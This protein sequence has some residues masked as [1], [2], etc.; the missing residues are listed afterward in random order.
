MELLVTLFLIGI[1]A[2]VVLPRL[3]GSHQK[4]PLTAAAKDLA[5]LMRLARS[6]AVTRSETMVIHLT[7]DPYRLVLVRAEDLERWQNSGQDLPAT[8]P[9]RVYHLPAGI[10]VERTV[11]EGDLRLPTNDIALFYPIG[12]SS[13]GR[14]VLTDTA[15]RR[16]TIQLDIVTGSV[17]I[18]ADARS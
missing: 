13:G 14:I 8:D 6:D 3:T 12:N 2:A 10:T 7:T 17:S 16:E 11:T 4:L 9:R 18:G 15:D 1:A 5:A